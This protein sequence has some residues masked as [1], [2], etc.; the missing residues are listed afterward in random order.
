M[1]NDIGSHDQRV[2]F[3]F[4]GVCHFGVAAFPTKIHVASETIET[5]CAV[6]CDNVAL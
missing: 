1:L 2:I 5:I 6:V 4:F 3:K